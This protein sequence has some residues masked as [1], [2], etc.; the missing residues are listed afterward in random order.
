[1]IAPLVDEKEDAAWSSVE[2]TFE[3]LVN[4]ELSEFRVDLVHGRQ[5]AEEKEAAMVRFAEGE[6]QVLVATTVVEV[7]INV[8]NATMMTILSASRFGLSQ[9]HQLRGRVGRG[10]QPGYVALFD[11]SD[12]ETTQE[13]LQSFAETTDGFKIAELDFELRGPGDLFG[14]KQHGMPPLFVA[15]LVR[16]YELLVKARQDANQLLEQDPQLEA[17][18]F[19][20]IRQ[21]ILARYG[22]SL[23]LSDVG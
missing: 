2:Q 10:N 6:T 22:E 8:P 11:D 19:A 5:S 4:G 18:D 21:R 15:D 1:M 12:S 9:L 13:R 20:E 14:T 17:D 3:S 16:D 7:G 23:E